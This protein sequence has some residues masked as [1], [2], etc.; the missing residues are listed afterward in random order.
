MKATRP[1]FAA[2]M[3]PLYAGV[4]FIWSAGYV[5]RHYDNGPDVW[6]MAIGTALVT[7]GATR[8]Y[9]RYFNRE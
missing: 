9:D 8:G 6:L 2:V 5:V 4:V 3:V 1:S 7:V